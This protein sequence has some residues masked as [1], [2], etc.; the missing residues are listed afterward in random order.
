MAHNQR[1]NQRWLVMLLALAIA[2]I[3]SG[4]EG[5]KTMQSPKKASAVMEESAM[6]ARATTRPV[7][8]ELPAAVRSQHSD[9]V[10][11]CQVGYLPNENKFA[12]LTEAPLG[13][14]VVRR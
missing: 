2:S 5:A 14:V 9:A 3:C 4:E 8:V 7:R 11:A 6:P 1:C 10:R 12:V 13:E